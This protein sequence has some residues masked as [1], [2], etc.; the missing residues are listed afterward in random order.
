[1]PSA[2]S[3]RSL[4]AALGLSR[5]TVSNALSGHPGVNAQTRQRV[6]AAAKA[7]GYQPH[8]FASRIMSQLRR[9]SKA[10]HVGTLAVLELEEQKRSHQAE[11][12]HRDLLGG[13]R[14]RATE[15]GFGVSH[16]K[17]GGASGLSLK[18][19]DEILQARGI[20]AVVFLPSCG[21]PDFTDLDWRRYVGIYLD[22]FIER[23]PLHTVSADHFRLLT[24]ALNQACELG[25]RRIGFAVTR[26]SNQRMHGLWVGAFRSFVHDHPEI[27]ASLLE[28]EEALTAEVFTS[29]FRRF[30]PEVVI[31]H[32]SEAPR[33][34]REAG[35]Q[36][37]QTHGYICLNL[38]PA[39]P[40]TSGFDFQPR[41][42]GARAA[43]LVIAQLE[44]NDQGPPAVPSIT[45]VPAR[46][47]PGGTIVRR[48]SAAEPLKAA[49]KRSRRSVLA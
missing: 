17:F 36:I 22:R 37:P 8:P 29:W 28:E 39:K 24:E 44:H 48:K 21:E 38:Q 6:Q 19:V 40:G 12:F 45:M 1:M 20:K 3:V 26:W 46:W 23:P 14:K 11:A 43:E 13:I 32:W 47:V 7:S 34:M 18:R 15:I 4:A 30:Q 49:A 25:Y 5:T 35:A 2:P 31:A 41:L 42:L 10:K 9:E 27:V 16:W 33:W